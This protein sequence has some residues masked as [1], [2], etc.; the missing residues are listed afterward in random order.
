MR[1]LLGPRG[2]AILLFAT[3][4]ALTFG[5]FPDRLGGLSRVGTGGQPAPLTV[6]TSTTVPLRTTSTVAPPSPRLPV[7]AGSTVPRRRTTATSP[8]SGTNPPVSGTTPVVTG[9]PPPVTGTTPPGTVAAQSARA[10]ALLPP[11]MPPVRDALQE[12]Q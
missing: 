10:P 9:T 5:F 12:G 7:N 3:V 6:G 4:T 8:V 11:A 1:R 2:G